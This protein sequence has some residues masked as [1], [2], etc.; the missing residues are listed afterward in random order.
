MGVP[1][2]VLPTKFVG[3]L[4]GMLPIKLDRERAA[5]RAFFCF[6]HSLC[7]YRIQRK[8][9]RRDTCF[10]FSLDSPIAFI[11][12]S[13]PGVLPG[14]LPTNQLHYSADKFRSLSRKYFLCTT[15]PQNIL[16]GFRAIF[17]RL[18]ILL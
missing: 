14:L 9:R 7:R 10:S 6:N 15:M 12:C 4:L 17:F 8:E 11:S 3:V 16:R 13:L 18:L 2:G 1:L 5:G